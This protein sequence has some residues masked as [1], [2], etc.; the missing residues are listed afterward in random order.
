[1]SFEHEERASTTAAAGAVWALWNDPGTWSV[2]DPA[3]EAVTIE[4]VEGAEG[5]ITLSGFEV[6]L[7]V[8]RVVPGSGYLSRITMGELVIRIDHVV[9]DTDEGGADIVVTTTIAGPGASDVGPMVVHDA[10]VALATICAMAEG[11]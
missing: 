3:V 10:P 11:R 7:V 2:W 4:L 5:T 8:E 6:P 9:T 1:M